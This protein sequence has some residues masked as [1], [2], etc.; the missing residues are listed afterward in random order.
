MKILIPLLQEKMEGE[1]LS[2]LPRYIVQAEIT[3]LYLSR[4][5]RKLTGMIWMAE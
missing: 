3:N 1:Q 4:F 2:Y 5:S